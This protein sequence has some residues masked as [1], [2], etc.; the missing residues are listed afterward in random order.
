L[1]DES[2]STP[3]TPATEV[4]D[5]PF[6]ITPDTRYREYTTRLAKGDMALC[7]TDAFSESRTA[8]GRMLGVEGL[9][10]VVSSIRVSTGEAFVAEVIES[11]RGLTAG[12][13]DQ[14]DATLMV[15]RANRKPSSIR[16]TL[17][18][19]F[20]LFGSVKDKST[21]RTPVAT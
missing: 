4:A 2:A 1:L 12:N 18:S 21:I 5:L 9:L 16:D 8:D 20:R 19:P 11:L 10:S 3:T 6:G 13:L 14:D 7:Y 17:M 15:F